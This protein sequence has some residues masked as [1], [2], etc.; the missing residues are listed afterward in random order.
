MRLCVYLPQWPTALAEYQQ[1]SSARAVQ[2]AHFRVGMREFRA[3][4]SKLSFQANGWAWTNYAFG[5]GHLGR[6]DSI[7]SIHS[8]FYQHQRNQL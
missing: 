4:F 5:R 6:W 2:F 7:V 8:D 1:S 3:L